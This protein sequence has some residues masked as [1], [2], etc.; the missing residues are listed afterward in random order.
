MMMETRAATMATSAATART[1]A[2]KTTT[3]RSPR[4]LARISASCLHHCPPS[5]PRQQQQLPHQRPRLHSRPHRNH[6]S[7]QCSVYLYSHATC[8]NEI[9]KCTGYIH[10]RAKGR[11]A[12]LSLDLPSPTSAQKSPASASASSPSPLTA[13]PVSPSKGLVGAS[14]KPVISPATPSAAT[15]AGAF[16]SPTSDNVGVEVCRI[17]FLFV[18]VCVWLH[19]ISF[20]GC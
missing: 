9:I 3:C 14:P 16:A 18:C 5:R 15:G 11:M 8:S 1:T 12:A 4:R 20:S 10:R 17:F 6:K 2:R 7:L 13:V 19:P